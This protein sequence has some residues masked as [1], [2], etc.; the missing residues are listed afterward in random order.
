[1]ALFFRNFQTLIFLIIHLSLHLPWE[2]NAKI[3]KCR[4]GNILLCTC[5]SA[6]IVGCAKQNSTAGFKLAKNSLI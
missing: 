2:F 5:F 3:G 6:A 1:M 4:V